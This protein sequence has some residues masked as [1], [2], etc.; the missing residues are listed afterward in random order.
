MESIYE[1]I[2]AAGSFERLSH[3]EEGRKGHIVSIGKEV[4]FIENKNAKIYKALNCRGKNRE[5]LTNYLI[6]HINKYP[7]DS[8]IAIKALRNDVAF[9]GFETIKRQYPDYH[10]KLVD[11]SQKEK[12]S[13]ELVVSKPVIQTV[14]LGKDNLETLLYDRIYAK[15]PSRASRC[16]GMLREMING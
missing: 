13:H 3:G 4:R 6:K 7:K 10:L 1:S 11:L 9:E 12:P 5:E 8:Y 2:Y 16:R 15:D 14:A